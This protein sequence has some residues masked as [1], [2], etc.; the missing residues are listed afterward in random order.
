MAHLKVCFVC[1]FSKHVQQLWL[2]CLLTIFLKHSLRRG[3]N[4]LR[5]FQTSSLFNLSD[6]KFCIYLI[7]ICSY[8]VIPACGHVSIQTFRPTHIHKSTLMSSTMGR[9]QTTTLTTTAT[10][11]TTTRTTIAKTRV[12]LTTMEHKIAAFSNSWIN[13]LRANYA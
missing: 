11:R 3:E 10:T 13:Y 4:S 8:S 12:P 6:T 9:L 7:L 2:K 5:S 1:W